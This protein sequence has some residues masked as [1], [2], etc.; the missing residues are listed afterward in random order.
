MRNERWLDNMI[1]QDQS[2]AV[3]IVEQLWYTWSDVGLDTLRAGARIR[4]ASDGLRD[5]RSARVQSL[6]RYQRYSLPPG[7]DPAIPLHAAPVCLSL[8]ATE[9]ERILVH[10]VYTGKDG[11]G[12]YGAFFV[13][14]LAGL[15]EHFSAYNAISLWQSKFW[16]RCDI[17]PSRDIP[18]SLQ[19]RLERLPLE[20]LWQ[21]S[22]EL[23]P[24]SKSSARIRKYLP[25]II[26]AYLT[27]KPVIE[28]KTKKK[29]PQKIYIAGSDSEIAQLIFGLTSCLPTHLLKELTFSTYE[30]N[31]S[32]ATT[33]IIGTCWLSV[34][35]AEKDSRAQRLLLEE[36]QQK[37]LTLNCYTGKWTELQDNPLV[38]NRPLTAKFAQD[39]TAYFLQ[40]GSEE[41]REKFLMLLDVASSSDVNELLTL[42]ESLIIQGE[43]PIKFLLLSP[44]YTYIAKN[45][46]KPVYPKA[47]IS[48]AMHDI[49]WWKLT[50]RAA[51][52]R[53]RQASK[54]VPLLA[55]GLREIAYTAI[56]KCTAIVKQGVIPPRSLPTSEVATYEENVFTTLIDVI[57]CAVPPAT[58]AT[59]WTSLL[60]ELLATKNIFVFL[61]RHWSIYA[62]LMKLWSSLLSSPEDISLI[63]PLLFVSWNTFGEFLALHLPTEWNEEATKKLVFDKTAKLSQ[64]RA[65][66]LAENYHDPIADLFQ[67]LVQIPQWWSTAWNLFARLVEGHYPQKMSLLFIML[68]SAMMQQHNDV[69]RLLAHAHLI[70]TDEQSCFL[71]RYGPL[72][73]PLNNTLSKIILDMFSI[74]AK[75]SD[76][77][78]QQHK[79]RVLA[80]WLRS[81]QLSTWFDLP[82]REG[83]NIATVL[84]LA[85]LTV[86]ECEEFFQHYGQAYILRDPTAPWLLNFFDAYA[87]DEKAR[88]LY[89]VSLWLDQDL[90][91]VTLE[92]V[93]KAAHLTSQEKITVLEHYG[94]HYLSRYWK[95]QILRD[96]VQEFVA[97]LYTA[98]LDIFKKTPSPDEP[99]L[100]E[101]FLAFLYNSG[102]FSDLIQY[103][104]DWYVTAML[105]RNPALFEQQR[106]EFA[107]SVGR[108]LKVPT[109]SHETYSDLLAML[110][111]ICL[112]YQQELSSTIVMMRQALAPSDLM[113]LTGEIAERA[114]NGIQQKL[115]KNSLF[116][117]CILFA[118][119]F[120]HAF[121]EK[122]EQD[123]F[124]QSFLD[125][126]LQGVDQKT[127]TWLNA[128]GKQWPSAITTQW[129]SYISQASLS[130]TKPSRIEQVEL[131]WERTIALYKMRQALRSN[132]FKRIARVAEEEMTT[133]T[134]DDAKVPEKWW[135]RINEAT[136]TLN[137]YEGISRHLSASPKRQGRFKQRWQRLVAFTLIGLAIRSRRIGRIVRVVTDQMHIVEHHLTDLPPWWWK[138]IDA[139]F[140]FFQVCEEALESPD[141]KREAAIIDAWEQLSALYEARHPAPV[142]TS[143]EIKRVKAAF[144][145][146]DSQM[147]GTL[148]GWT[149]T[150]L[151]PPN[152]EEHK[153]FRP[154]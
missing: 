71:E 120:Q 16:Q 126:L 105:V 2:R 144:F 88:R 148:K 69:A 38:E 153:N 135:N 36:Y 31:V 9:Q 81:P 44:D 94:E 13:H 48:L 113:Y 85:N 32:G 73:L 104:Y 68:D 101:K 12:R 136:D 142:L 124:V 109:L 108:I 133:L 14:L 1:D 51:I 149:P 150:T 10:K 154:R 98:G 130:T 87:R 129:K 75:S 138:Q 140:D 33:E 95:L 4:A 52:T 15:P 43:T 49:D 82:S 119:H 151:L 139:T 3:D 58:D 146:V 45:L 77:S 143:H 56:A 55:Q 18:L 62:D 72:Y 125:T 137:T 112:Q 111:I 34:P 78:A 114:R 28:P 100:A 89:Y 80:S 24:K 7:A 5:I 91:A 22:K 59:V 27:K 25:Y 47:L 29:V 54:K 21:E 53:L 64:E 39:A 134:S 84:K 83:R 147:R 37:K 30:P 46:V 11:V 42:Y 115:Y 97:Y 106:R 93:L 102:R 70:T 121:H 50:G 90:D 107:E 127:L 99:S 145:Y 35:E 117:A 116:G 141:E 65:Y 74:L 60:G 122:R 67:Q 63:Y 17:P 41:F 26:E 23:T 76:S 132:N 6:D 152:T 92:R 8:I 128:Q 19:T 103:I 66:E 61:Q 110:A 57:A 20:I 96:Y 79:K 86:Q 40:E 118:F 131:W 123:Y